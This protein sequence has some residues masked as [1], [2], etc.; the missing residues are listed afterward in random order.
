MPR[1]RIAKRNM[2]SRPGIKGLL[3]S[4]ALCYLAETTNNTPTCIYNTCLLSSPCRA[5]YMR[6]LCQYQACTQLD[7]AH[8]YNG[9]PGPRV[10]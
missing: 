6:G 2:G 4:F 3:S 1:L 7:M 8:L 9:L 10:T 5:G